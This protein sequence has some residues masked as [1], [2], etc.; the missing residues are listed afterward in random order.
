MNVAQLRAVLANLPDD[1]PVVGFW[2]SITVPVRG[3]VI[4]S[5]QLLLDVDEA[6]TYRNHYDWQGRD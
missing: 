5:A 3:W 2:E 1:M 6:D 4:D